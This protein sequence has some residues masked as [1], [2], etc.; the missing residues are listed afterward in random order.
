MRLSKVL[1]PAR[2]RVPIGAP[3][4]VGVIT[5]LID[6][7]AAD[8]ALA[9]RQTCLDAVL[10]RESEKTTGIGLGLAIPHGRSEGVR[11]VAMAAG[12]TASPVDF[13]SYDRR[14]VNFVLLLLS[15]PDQPT[16]HLQALSEISRLMNIDGFRQA[17]ARAASADEL[18]RAICAFEASDAP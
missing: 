14:P 6:V 16:V 3:D 12:R 17:V 4:K 8:G 11:Q 2:L 18:F 13:Q 7:L 5:E 15:P 1:T 10:K 9:D